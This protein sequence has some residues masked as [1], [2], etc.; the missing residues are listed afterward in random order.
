MKADER[1]ITK[2]LE[3]C[4][5]TIGDQ[6]RMANAIM[7]ASK[8]NRKPDIEHHI[9]VVEARWKQIEGLIYAEQVR[10]GAEKTGT[11]VFAST[12]DEDS[13]HD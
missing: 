6:V 13:S 3:L 9:A 12:R 5:Q 2:T 8:F 1:D 10:L 11:G 4:R 7:R